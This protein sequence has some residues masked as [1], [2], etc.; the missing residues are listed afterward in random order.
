[1]NP[2]QPDNLD[3]TR[4][5]DAAAAD[6]ARQA[7]DTIGRY[8]I[9]R[10]VGEGGMGAVF[11][12]QQEQ[13]RR[14]VALKVIK[15]GVSTTELLRRFELEAQALGRLQHP[16]IG[17]I[18]EAGTADTG[19]GP[20]PY[21]AM[22][23]I[24]GETLLR[25]AA[26]HQLDTRQRLELLA[27]VC[28]AIQHAHQRGIIHRDLK[29]GNIMVDDQGQPKVLDFG[30]ARV[31][32]SDAQATRHTDLGQLVGTLAYMSPEQV[33]ADPLEL[34]TRSDVYALGVILFELLAGRLP[35]TIGGKVHEAV[36][37]IREDDP[38]RLSSVDRAYR[39][40]IETIA[41]KALEK[42]KARRYASAAGLAADIR[43]YLNHEPIVARPAT[44]AYQLR[45]FA[46]RNRALVGGVAA[47]FAVLVLGVIVSLGQATRAR[48]AERT[49][50]QQR[51]RATSAERSANQQ[52]DLSIAERDRA[53]AAESQAQ[54]QRNRAMAEQKRADTEAA[55]AKA[56]NE[57]LRDDLLGQ[58]GPYVQADEG[59][60]ADP[61]IKVRTALDRASQQVE[62]KFSDRPL[63][64]AAIRETIGNSYLDLG[65]YAQSETQLTRS[66]A[67]RRRLLG[68]DDKD[69][70]ET[71]GWLGFVYYSEAKYAQAEALLTSMLTP[72]RL[73]RAG[74]DPLIRELMRN[75]GQVYTET[76]RYQSAEEL[77]SR[78]LSLTRRQLGDEDSDT[79]ILMGA[80]AWLYRLENKLPQAEK[81]YSDA[82]E[83]ERRRSGNEHPETLTAMGNL[84][85]L[86]REEGKLAQAETLLT[87]VT[88]AGPK[89]FGED[90]PYVLIHQRQLGR[91]RQSQ[92]RYSE[93][94]VIVAAALEKSR[95]ALGEEDST[96]L[97]TID[98]LSQIYS[99]EGKLQPAEALL[100]ELVE[101]RRR[102]LGEEHADTVEAMDSLGGVYEREAR[103]AQAEDLLSKVAEIRR[104]RPGEENPLTLGTMFRL[105]RVFRTDGKLAQAEALLTRTVDI[106]RR[107]TG[108]DRPET[109]VAGT[110]LAEVIQ[111]EGRIPEAEKMYLDLI[112]RSRRALKPDDP[113][114]FNRLGFLAGLYHGEHE[115]DKAEPLYVEALEGRRRALG[116][117]DPSTLAAMYNLGLLY[118]DK[119]DLARAEPLIGKVLEMRRTT[120]GSDAPLT[121][122]TIAAMALL[123]LEQKNYESAEALLRE[124]ESGYAKR[125][126]NNWIRYACQTMLGAAL[127]GRR[128]YDEAER[129]LLAGYEGMMLRKNAIPRGNLSLEHAAGW[130]ADLYQQWN[131]PDKAAEWRSRH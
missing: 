65:V 101:K 53:I 108:G 73:S 78:T 44:T 59:R 61:D 66:L 74:R 20:Q 41:G 2:I 40:D 88:A 11:E 67:I 58:A 109:L 130:L 83:I 89:V 13:P 5:V 21:F 64:E 19:F 36:R 120:L 99:A 28:D 27:K 94:E 23:F 50:L 4:T 60:K 71:A 45:K 116:E 70:L 125:L 12:A 129:L 37:A 87:Q 69:T 122:S 51:D 6:R 81:L 7:P 10:L 113:T 84:A 114:L 33:L 77:L 97:G 131:K 54:E 62:K 90:H 123:R 18:F 96:T 15:A 93:A 104:R 76:G 68:D 32:D 3:I 29:P 128:Q 118:R 48:M 22:E 46:R 63:V 117:R 43:H 110:V 127:A 14:T 1:V 17:Q 124:A 38:A 31:T 25:Y 105:G 103:Y 24:R 26:S 35:Y 91:L 79:L 16:G 86:Y 98:Q 126:P 42:E 8:R 56:V 9:V 102:I 106:R 115:Y 85:D 57:F 72:Q 121:L 80:L 82:V 30:V 34:D 39:G 119:G 112:A 95:R 49:A 47:V 100:T 92:G 75:L 111:A 52:R 55:T 107:V